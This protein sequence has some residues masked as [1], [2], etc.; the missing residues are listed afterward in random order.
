MAISPS[1]IAAFECLI[2]IDLRTS[3]SSDALAGAEEKLGDKDRGLCHEIVLGSLRRQIYLDRLI[4]K[5][6]GAKKLDRAV[7][8]ALRMGIYQLLFLD[9]VPAFSAINESVELVRR[10]KK[11]SATGFV[12]AILRRI[13]RVGLDLTFDDDIDKISVETSHPRWLIER[14]IDEFGYERTIELA[15][16]NNTEPPLAFRRT[17]RSRDVDLGEVGR[18]SA[19]VEGCLLGSGNSRRLL[20]L[21]RAGLVYFQDES[22]Q[23]VASAVKAIEGETILDVC[24]APGSKTGMIAASGG[25]RVVAGDVTGSRLATLGSNLEKQGVSGVRLCQYDASSDLPFADAAFDIV[26][27]DAPCSGT[28]TI[29]HNPEIRYSLSSDDFERH[30]SKQLKIALNASKTL[31]IG[32][33]MIYS[34]CSLEREENEDVIKKL[35]E[36][37][38]GLKVTSPKVGERFITDEGFA[39]TFPDRD[40]MDG[41]F[42]AQLTRCS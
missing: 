42:I 6:A 32:G 3:F 30:S 20:E 35:L 37:D 39:R 25:G 29:R 31:K 19:N 12:N 13:T 17:T 28:G 26:I 7:R 33:R 11:A 4:A 10:A 1:R 2:A 24:A 15:H 8:V 21:E 27:V 22:S 16:A 34:T 23:L 9:R 5:F 14:W 40:D 18:A 36:I 41:F 38:P